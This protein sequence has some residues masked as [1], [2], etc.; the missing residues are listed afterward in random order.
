VS[1]A[2]RPGEVQPAYVD[3]SVVVPTR[4]AESLVEDC[5]SSI[6]RSHPREIIVVDGLS[7]DRTVEIARRHGATVLSDEGRGLP[8]ARRM[9]AEAAGSQHVA[10][11]DV[12]VRMGDGDLARLL[13]EFTT[14]GYTALQAGL[15]SV[16]G[17]GYW[18][19]ALANHHRTGRSKNWFG[20]VATVFDRHVLLKHGFDDRFLSG[21]DIDLRWRLLRA[22]AKIGVSRRTV[23]EH[24][25]HDT[26]E[27]AKG[28]FVADG[29]GLGRMVENHG[30]RATALLGLPA[31][32]AVR[33]ILLS[34]VRLQPQWIPYYLVYAFYNYVAMTQELAAGRKRRSRGPGGTTAP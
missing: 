21:E 29:H 25:F 33:G 17:S 14:E 6:E 4:N 7:T 27:F 12:D 24:R 32:G 5:L 10:L 18:G 13:D 2:R 30:I 9:G 16:S 15:H 3:V 28:Q 11:I 22:G 8:A 1:D 20:V 34:L 23:V 31:A 19:R 26:W